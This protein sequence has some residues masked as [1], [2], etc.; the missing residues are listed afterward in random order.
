MVDHEDYDDYCEPQ[1]PE[2]SAPVGTTR[3]R[4]RRVAA[5]CPSF[6]FVS[7]P[8]H[9]VFARPLRTGPPN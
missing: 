2:L 9:R 4:A 5:A 1:G 6:A 7:A 8:S 3:T